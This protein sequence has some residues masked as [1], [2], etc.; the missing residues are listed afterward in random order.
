MYAQIVK[1][2]L[3]PESSRELFLKF[4]EEM[5]EWLKEQV[6]FVAYEIYEGPDSWTDRIVWNTELQAKDGLHKFLAISICRKNF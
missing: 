5:I 1:F 3:K 4:T 2:N 6:G